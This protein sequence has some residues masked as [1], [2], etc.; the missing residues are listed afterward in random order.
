MK[1]LL[2]NNKNIFHTKTH[3]I[4]TCGKGRE[5]RVSVPKYSL[6]ELNFW[7]SVDAT[8]HVLLP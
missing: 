1:K 6:P 8:I 5:E 3:S 2:K 7:N 4:K